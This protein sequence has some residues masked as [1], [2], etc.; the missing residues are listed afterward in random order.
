MTQAREELDVPPE[1]SP[2]PLDTV[3]LEASVE[4]FVDVPSCVEAL[5]ARVPVELAESLAD[6]GYGS[7]LDDVCGGLGAAKSRDA[8]SCDALSA[9]SLRDGC[10]RRVALLAHDPTSCPPA[11]GTSGRDPSCLAW[12]TGDTRLCAALVG[13]AERTCRAVGTN[14]PRACRGDARCEATVRRYGPSVAEPLEG[15]LPSS[16]L[17]VT[18]TVGGEESTFDASDAL[19]RG[20][21]LSTE[22]CAHRLRVEV[23]GL[24]SRGAQLELDVLLRPDDGAWTVEPR[25]I[26]YARERL[27]I[28]THVM[29]V[30]VSEISVEPR[31]GGAWVLSLR[32]RVGLGTE[33]DLKLDARGWVRDVD[34]LPA[35]CAAGAGG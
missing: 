8:S 9:T 1:P 15:E 35:R 33:R 11:R 23:G 30:V 13:D 12:A 3:S 16:A 10:R 34:P 26:R 22:G 31:L 5:R 28:P 21:V 6:L 17:V 4:R 24:L 25:S 20:T 2:W 32:G 14:E 29:D 27:A 18:D 19:A 7:A